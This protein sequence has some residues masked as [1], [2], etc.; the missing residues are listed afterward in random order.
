MMDRPHIVRDP[1]S[2]RYV[3][4]IKVMSED[5]TQSATVLTADDVFG[6]YEIVRSGL[7]P[8]GMSAGDLDL[9]VDPF[10]GKGYYFFER[11]HSELICADL[12]PDLTDVTGYY[13]T[14]FPRPHPPF[15]RE[16]PA[17]FRRKGR[18]YLV[19]SGTTGY[20]PNPSEVAVAETYHGPWTV[21]G[22]LHPSDESRTSFR[23]QISSV[24]RHP[25]KT[26][27]YIAIADRWRPDL[28][29]RASDRRD[30]YAER[31]SGRM[32]NERFIAELGD[33]L[34]AR[35]DT[36]QATPVWLP[37]VFDGDRPI[38]EWREQWSPD[39]YA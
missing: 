13:S 33:S 12:T 38:V 1:A 2:G 30:L 4:W 37:I 17:Y 27:L 5:G 19:T 3:C 6:P 9:V 32:S 31:F 29:A 16:A 23:S 35:A 18:H 34:D 24:F 15:V 7:R 20:L 10:D 39:D 14:H 36:S 26:D 22:D 28:D 8:L 21:L 11:V 25:G